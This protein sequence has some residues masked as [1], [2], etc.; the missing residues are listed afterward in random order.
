MTRPGKAIHS[1]IRIVLG[2]LVLVHDAHGN[3]GAEGDA[4]FRAGV[5]LDAVLFV[6]RR[7]DGALAR[8]SACELGLDV[9]LVE[10]ETWRAAVDYD[11]DGETVGFTIATGKNGVSVNARNTLSRTTAYVWTRKCC[12][13]VD[14]VIYPN[15]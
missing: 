6:A 10:G 9:G 8:T 5:D 4:V 15:D 13:N 7:R 11:S 12:P 1:I 3:R 14:I 2:P